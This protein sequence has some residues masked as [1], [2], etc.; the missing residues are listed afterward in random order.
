MSQGA[1]TPVFFKGDETILAGQTKV[2]H[3]F[4]INQF[5]SLN[6]ILTFNNTAQTK[7]KTM[8][9]A[10]IKENAL[11][12]NVFGKLGKQISI[13]IDIIDNA[14]NLELTVE[15]K[16]LFDIKCNFGFAPLGEA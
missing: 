15:N 14:G 13:D 11:Q 6:Y 4:P 1:F 2:I 3:S 8:Q 5:R 10:I 16:E 9:I 7:T 12:W